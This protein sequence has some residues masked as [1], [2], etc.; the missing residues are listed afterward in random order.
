MTPTD[1]DVGSGTPVG[2]TQVNHLIGSPGLLVTSISDKLLVFD[3]IG[4]AAHCVSGVAAWLLT[5]NLPSPIDTLIDQLCADALLPHSDAANAVQATAATL[6]DL[7]L[8]NR[9]VRYTVPEPLTAAIAEPEPGWTVGAAHS[10][11][12][13][14]L[15][16]CGPDPDLIER[17]DSL[18]GVLEA[19]CAGPTA[20]F[21]VRRGPNGTIR[22]DHDTFITFDSVDQMLWQLPGE[23]NY[24][25]SHA[26]TMPVL[27]AGAVRTPGGRIIVVTGPIDAG[28]STLVAALVRAGCDYASDESIGI[29]PVSGHAWAYAK[30][31]TMDPTTQRLVGL[32]PPDVAASPAEHRRADEIRAG[33]KCLAGDIGPV[34]LIVD[35]TYRPDEPATTEFYDPVVAAQR[36]LAN[37][38]NPY[39]MGQSGL[40]ALCHLAGTARSCRLVHDSSIDAVAEVID[41]A[42]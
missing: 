16:F 36:L 23:L 7:G 28:K 26:A 30:P 20:Y 32:D 13:R 19:G 24:F 41:L 25:M 4:D 11:L 33:A 14:T 35:V 34:D 3:P 21:G 12:D 39:R 42:C 2:S 38:L 10:Y 8:L 17:I 6:V 29:D 9:V 22:I 1:G 37:T 18:L 5:A 31:L 27:H 15:A 40:D